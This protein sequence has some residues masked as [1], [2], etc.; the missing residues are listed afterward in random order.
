MA[1]LPEKPA[2]YED[3][4]QYNVW[5]VDVPK[6]VKRMENELRTCTSGLNFVLC[7]KGFVRLCSG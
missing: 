2:N 4:V 6:P 7:R 3:I 5:V 1:D